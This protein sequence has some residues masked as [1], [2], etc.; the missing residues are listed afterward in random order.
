MFGHF[1]GRG[2]GFPDSTTFDKLFC[3]RL[4]IAFGFQ[5]LFVFTWTFFKLNLVDNQSP[6]PLRNFSWYKIRFKKSSLNDFF[7]K[8]GGV[9]KAKLKKTKRK[10]IG[11]MD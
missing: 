4:D 2:G 3:L 1:S 6:N 9:V 7:L 8:Q 11:T 10:Q 5:T